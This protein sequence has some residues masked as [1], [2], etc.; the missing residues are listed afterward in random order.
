MSNVAF[1]RQMTER[2]Y[3]VERGP[4]GKPARKPGGGQAY[5]SGLDLSIAGK[6]Y[7]DRARFTNRENTS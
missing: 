2:G 1:S 4:D 3:S 5:Y 6:G 7:L